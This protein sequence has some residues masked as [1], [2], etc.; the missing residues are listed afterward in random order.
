[1]EGVAWAIEEAPADPAERMLAGR[2]LLRRLAGEQLGLAPELVPL[3]ARCPDCGGPHGRPVVTGSELRVSLSRCAAGIVAVAVWGRDIGVD[4]EAR[5]DEAGRLAAIR[6]V[7]G[8]GGLAHWTRVEAVLKAD[9]RGLRV[10]P[11]T[12]G[13]V[14]DG[15]GILTATVADTGRRYRILEPALDPHLAPVLQLSIALA[16]R[17]PR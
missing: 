14:A 11:R 12:V 15:D 4:V 7:A 6:E 8:G 1:M 3:E 17:P 5:A 16:S 2:M 9:G 10:D 13:I